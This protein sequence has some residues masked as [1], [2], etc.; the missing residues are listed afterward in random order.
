LPT[1]LQFAAELSDALRLVLRAE[2]EAASLSVG[3]LSLRS[4]L[5]RQAITFIEKGER[6][7]TT[8]TLSRLAMALGMLP[9]EAW[10]KAEANVSASRLKRARE[11]ATKPPHS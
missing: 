9:S 2:R 8:E 6:R 10:K 1:D 11:S 7:P 4:G 3:E 5:N